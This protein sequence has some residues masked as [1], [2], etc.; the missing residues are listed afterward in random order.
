MEKT[1]NKFKNIRSNFGIVIIVI[2]LT[3]FVLTILNSFFYK[4]KLFNSNNSIDNINTDYIKANVDYTIE[5]KEDKAT[6]YLNNIRSKDDLNLFFENYTLLAKEVGV[7]SKENVEVIPS[8]NVLR[9]LRDFE[10]DPKMLDLFILENQN[11]D[12]NEDV[13]E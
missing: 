9:R 11:L 12:L 1:K 6:I 2:I 5:V 3:L 13:S 4:G 7:S 10:E 8:G